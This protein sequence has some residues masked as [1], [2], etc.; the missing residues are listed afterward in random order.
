MAALKKSERVEEQREQEDPHGQGGI[1]NWDKAND[2]RKI[3]QQHTNA[4]NHQDETRTEK[5]PTVCDMII[6]VKME[7]VSNIDIV[8]REAIKIERQSEGYQRYCQETSV[9]FE[10]W[11]NKF[12]GSSLAESE[13]KKQ[14]GKNEEAH[15]NAGRNH[16]PIN[17][18][19]SVVCQC[20]PGDWG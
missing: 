20:Q 19:V 11:L 5:R 12:D 7:N 3:A 18:L 16:H 9:H 4:P 1:R 13:R 14:D 10:H 15:P 6:W 17:I 8:F 2:I